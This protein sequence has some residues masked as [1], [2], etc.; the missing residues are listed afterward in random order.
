VDDPF[1]G[2]ELLR[3]DLPTSRRQGR[4]MPRE[5]RFSKLSRRFAGRYELLSALFENLP[6]LLVAQPLEERDLAQFF[7]C[8]HGKLDPERH[9]FPSALRRGTLPVVR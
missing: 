1:Q 3:I 8:R 9:T 2:I 6:Q 4:L 5:R 7:K